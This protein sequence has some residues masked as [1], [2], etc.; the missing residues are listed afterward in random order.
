MAGPP[1]CTAEGH[2][3]RA[4]GGAGAGVAPAAAISRMDAVRITREFIEATGIVCGR[5]QPVW[6]LDE[7]DIE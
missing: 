6:N 2:E 1:L 7:T 4:A 5:P 3:L